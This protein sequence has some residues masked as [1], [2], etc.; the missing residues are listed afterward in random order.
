MNRSAN[1]LTYSACFLLLLACQ[2]SQASELASVTIPASDIGQFH[3]ETS[4]K[5]VLGK[6]V[7]D[8]LGEHI[9]L[10]TEKPRASP[11]GRIEHIELVAAY[12]DQ[13]D[14][15]WAPS[16]TIKDGVDCPGLDIAASFFAGATTITDLDKDGKAEVTV[17]YKTF[18]G[19]GVDP[20]IVKVILRQGKQKFAIRGESLIKFKGQEPMGGTNK[21]D[22]AL[23]ESD[24]AA[25]KRHMDKVWQQ[26]YVEVNDR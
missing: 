19:G 25:F 11:N 9:L 16:W 13:A 7:N 22:K 2:S 10:L 1:T 26:V 17:A 18:C 4:G 14:G 3:L 20:S 24:K 5:V 12:Y 8:S 6:K 21:A 15:K 23:L